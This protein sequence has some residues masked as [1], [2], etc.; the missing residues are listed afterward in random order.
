MTGLPPSTVAQDYLKLVWTAREWTDQPVTT[1]MLASRLGVAASTASEAV[2]RL[3]GQGLLRHAPYGSI[4]LTERGELTALTMV[5]RHRL[6][7][8]FLVTVLGYTW[9]EAHDDAEI[10]EHA[11]SDRFIDRVDETLGHPVRD[12][13][14]DPI[15]RADGTMVRPPALP[16][17]MLNV[18]VNAQVVRISDADSDIL[19]YLADVGVRLD[20]EVTVRELRRAGGVIV[21]DVAGDSLDLGIPAARAVWVAPL[22]PGRSYPKP[23]SGLTG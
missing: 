20:A 15:P 3:A 12:P 13:H 4:E 9:D 16:L 10:L 5:R 8:T 2:K 11:A 17:T 14:G 22:D 23:G 18:G 19:R 6:L 1:T 7:E 21:L